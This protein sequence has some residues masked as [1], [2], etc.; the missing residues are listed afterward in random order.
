MK[1]LR[2]FVFVFFATSNLLA[3]TLPTDFVKPFFEDLLND[4]YSLKKLYSSNKNF[5]ELD[6]EINVLNEKLKDASSKLGGP[7]SYEKIKEEKINDFYYIYHYA[8]KYER[9]PLIFKFIFYKP[10]KEYQ[11]QKFSFDINLEPYLSQEK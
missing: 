5:T 7:Y 9:Q 1:I 2:V 8:V 3:Q 4:K 10:D 6:N 11:L